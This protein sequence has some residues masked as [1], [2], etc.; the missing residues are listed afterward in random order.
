MTMELQDFQL[1]YADTVL[2]IHVYVRADQDVR[3]LQKNVIRAGKGP[4]LDAIAA[5]T[6]IYPPGRKLG[7]EGDKFGDQM[8][9]VEEFLRAS[10][11]DVVAIHLFINTDTD[12]KRLGENVM[13]AARGPRLDAVTCAVLHYEGEEGRKIWGVIQG[14]VQKVSAD[15]NARP[16][17]T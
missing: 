15:P 5:W 6:E 4:R 10:K 7:W 11:S 16:F 1:K 2:A 13:R 3:K 8:A 12:P 9:Q 14:V 17:S